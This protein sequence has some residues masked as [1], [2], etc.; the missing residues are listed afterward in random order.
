MGIK[1]PKSVF[2]YLGVF[3]CLNLAACRGAAVTSHRARHCGS[4]ANVALADNSMY[5]LSPARAI[6]ATRTRYVRV[7][8]MAD[9][10]LL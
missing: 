1:V 4:A 5:A 8:S 6:A 10:L 7:S 3:V 2:F 9:N